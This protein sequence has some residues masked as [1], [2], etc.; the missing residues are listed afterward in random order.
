[1]NCLI[2][3]FSYR[4]HFCCLSLSDEHAAFAEGLKKQNQN[5]PKQPCKYSFKGLAILSCQVQGKKF[6]AI[7]S[8][9]EKEESWSAVA[10]ISVSAVNH[11]N[12]LTYRSSSLPGLAR[13][14]AF[15][16]VTPWFSNRRWIWVKGCR[17]PYSCHWLQDDRKKQQY[18]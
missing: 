6:D 9:L 11:L 13:H 17:F 7:K 18:V 10:V 2:Q 14:L 4:F 3:N 5:P 12:S 16:V 1:M 8:E 15:A